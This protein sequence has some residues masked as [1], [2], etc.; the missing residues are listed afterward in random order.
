MVLGSELNA[1]TN[2]L[3]HFP[4]STMDN[5]HGTYSY[6]AWDWEVLSKFF[7]IYNIEQN[8]LDCNFTVGDYDEELGGWTG[9]VG[10]V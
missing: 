6:M 8:W 7:S 2:S 3:I 4:R 5:I 10:Q 9:C 1:K